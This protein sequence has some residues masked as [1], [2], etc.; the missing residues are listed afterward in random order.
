VA[1]IRIGTSGFA[2]KEWK[3]SFYPSD[4]PQR[5]FLEYYA[6]ELRAVEID[7]TF[8]RMPT[9]STLETWLGA[10]SDDFR[11]A[12]KASRRITHFGRLRLPSDPLDHLLSVLPTLGE[13]LGVL[14][15]QLP[16][17]FR[18]DTNRLELFLDTLPDTV[19]CAFEFRH[20][21]WFCDDVYSLLG[22]YSTALVIHDADDHTTPLRVTSPTAYV[23][24]RRSLYTPRERDEWL[25]RFRTWKGEGVDVFGFIKHADNP[26]A[27]LIAREFARSV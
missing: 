6:T 14:L 3:P 8:Y 21:S 17:N 19:P 15:F 1:D 2:Y 24:L 22:K 9:A 20:E 23:R 26:D 12:L 11:F 10:T 7:Y 5:R 25:T 4:L 16:P 18:V 13:R 27:P